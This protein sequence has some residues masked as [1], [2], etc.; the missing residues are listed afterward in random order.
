[1][2]QIGFHKT[3]IHIILPIV[4]DRISFKH[5]PIESLSIKEGGKWAKNSTKNRTRKL[6]LMVLVELSEAH[7]LHLGRHG[8]SGQVDYHFGEGP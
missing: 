2:G 5:S 7:T 4:G 6:F 1:M 8:T 3:N